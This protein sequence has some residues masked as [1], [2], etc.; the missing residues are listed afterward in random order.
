MW[1]LWCIS[2]NLKKQLQNLWSWRQNYCCFPDMHKLSRLFSVPY[3]FLSECVWVCVYTVYLC[4]HAKKL[5]TQ[6]GINWRC[7]CARAAP[8]AA[9]AGAR[10]HCASVTCARCDV[11][12]EPLE[13]QPIDRS[14]AHID[15]PRTRSDLAQRFSASAVWLDRPNR[16]A[17]PCANTPQLLR[18]PRYQVNMRK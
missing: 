16:L 18:N 2:W 17:V 5:S 14:L 3:I 4:V 10:G 8:V 13:R 7:A 9:A 11:G 1:H 12:D 6:K 15:P